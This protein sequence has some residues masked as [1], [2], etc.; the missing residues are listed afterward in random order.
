MASKVMNLETRLKLLHFKKS[1]YLSK[2]QMIY[3]YSLNVTEDNV[4]EYLQLFA[5]LDDFRHLFDI[6]VMEIVRLEMETDTERDTLLHET[7]TFQK[8]FSDCRMAAIKYKVVYVEKLR[9][10]EPSLPKVRLIEFDG[11]IENWKMFYDTFLSL[12]HNRDM[13][14]IDKFYY[15][16]TSVKGPALSIVRNWPITAENYPLAW[17]NLI[18]TYQNNRLLVN[19]YI[20]KMLNFKS[21]T[22]ASVSN[23]YSFLD[24]FEN[25]RKALK[26]L[27]VH[28]IGDY[29]MFHMALGALDPATKKLFEESHDQSELP[30]FS[31]LINFVGK[32]IKVLQVTT[33][34]TSTVKEENPMDAILLRP[35]YLDDI[36]TLVASTS[37]SNNK[38]SKHYCKISCARCTKNYMI[39]KCKHLRQLSDEKKGDTEENHYLMV[40]NDCVSP[41]HECVSCNSLWTCEICAPRHKNLLHKDLKSILNMSSMTVS[42][43]PSTSK[44]SVP[45]PNPIRK[46]MPAIEAIPRPFRKDTLSYGVV[47][48]TARVYIMDI[49]GNKHDARA[50][51]DSGAQCSFITMKCA[52][53]LGFSLRPCSFSIYGLGGK[54]LN[55]YGT[56]TCSIKSHYSKYPCFVTDFVV[57]SKVSP[58]LPSIS[59]SSKITNEYKNMQLADPFF[60]KRSRID[61]LLGNNIVSEIIKDKPLLLKGSIPHVINT[62]FGYV[63]SGRLYTRTK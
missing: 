63:V 15:L 11:Q 3:D 31:E 43:V 58:D 5:E 2:L 33:P 24:A 48:G 21:L 27:K 40:C 10:I 53:R 30:K 39:Y 19:T 26:A 62:I 59:I 13:E 35:H 28:D 41:D 56:I 51:I 57:V 42:V 22:E 50:V 60:Y 1:F 45:V 38:N 14:N 32:Q 61:I 47:L 34:G 16:L 49:Y 46:L 6:A 25:S 55:N 44:K 52:Q 8:L 23:L 17:Q 4:A 36:V 54:I 18:D 20:N 9:S 29:L 7:S 37:S 12:V